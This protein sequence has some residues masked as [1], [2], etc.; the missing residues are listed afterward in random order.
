MNVPLHANNYCSYYYIRWPCIALLQY[1]YFCI[2]LKFM[3]EN[4]PPLFSTRLCAVLWWMFS[5]FFLL[6][7]IHGNPRVSICCSRK[8]SLARPSMR[9]MEH[10]S[11]R[12]PDRTTG[13]FTRVY[14]HLPL[15]NMQSTCTQYM[16][17]RISFLGC[18]LYRHV[19]KYC[20]YK[21]CSA[22]LSSWI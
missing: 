14:F 4:T 9:L 18:V 2:H 17:I 21:T 13:P 3:T 16:H 7:W 22:Y 15:H 1:M 12:S 8:K 11:T 20:V 19:Q 10:L 5:S 6:G